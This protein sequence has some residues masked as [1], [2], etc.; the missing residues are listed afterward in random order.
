MERP[1]SARGVTL[2]ELMFGM[3]IVSV[4]LTVGIPLFDSLYDKERLRGAATRL[5]AE[6][7]QA[8]A[9]AELH[10]R[11]VTVTVRSGPYWC[12]GLSDDGACDC[13][14]QGS[15][16]VNGLVREVAG[17]RFRG[18]SIPGADVSTTFEP[19]QDL[20]WEAPEEWPILLESAAGRRIAVSLNRLG[21]A[22]LCAPQNPGEHW[23]YED[24]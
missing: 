7:R 13:H 2:L 18:V 10:G 4:L 17:E 21:N 11:S 19:A 15:C 16:R 5:A 6:T 14:T 1:G 9:E 22:D 3:F 12:I 24:C 8:R 23:S 20:S